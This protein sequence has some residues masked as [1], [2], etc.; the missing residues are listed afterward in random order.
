MWEDTIPKGP[1]DKQISPQ[2]VPDINEQRHPEQRDDEVFI[3]NFETLDEG[4][5]QD[6]RTEFEDM[7]YRTKRQGTVVDGFYPV[8]V[9]KSEL[10]K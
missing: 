1:E 4:Q 10:E 7:P 6:E 2:E 3:G 8:F 5:E 9:K